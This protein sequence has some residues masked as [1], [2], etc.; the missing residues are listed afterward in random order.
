MTPI[1]CGKRAKAYRREYFNGN[2]KSWEEGFKCKWCGRIRIPHQFPFPT[3][4]MDTMDAIR[5]A[6][7]L[8]DTSLE[9]TG[10]RNRG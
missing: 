8:F 6:G 5:E 3:E 10:D 1:C 2:S 9:I 4:Y 7:I